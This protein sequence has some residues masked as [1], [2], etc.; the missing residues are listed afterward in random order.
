VTDVE[1]GCQ[2]QNSTSD[3]RGVATTHTWF[4]SI[5]CS[6]VQRGDVSADVT[7]AFGA[8]IGSALLV[9]SSGVP[10]IVPPFDTLFL[11]LP[12]FVFG[13]YICT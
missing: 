5:L 7:N 10:G 4:S 1:H 8:S 13:G 2:H 9:M 3:R 6:V 12:F 11:G